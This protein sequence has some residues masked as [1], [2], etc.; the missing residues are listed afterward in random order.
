MGLLDFEVV[1]AS[2]DGLQHG[3]LCDWIITDITFPP[4]YLKEL[5]ELNNERKKDAEALGDTYKPLKPT[6]KDG[7]MAIKVAAVRRKIVENPDGTTTS[8]VV[9]KDDGDGL[10]APDYVATATF[11]HLPPQK[12]L[13]IEG[14]NGRYGDM[15]SWGGGKDL[16]DGKPSRT[17]L[18]ESVKPIKEKTKDGSY[19]SV[20]DLTP[21]QAEQ[22]ATL[23]NKENNRKNSWK[24][25]ISMWEEASEEDRE[26]FLMN[27]IAKRLFICNITDGKPEYLKLTEGIVFRAFVERNGNSIYPNITATIYDASSNKSLMHNFYACKYPSETMLTFVKEVGKAIQRKIVESREKEKAALAKSEE[28]YRN[29]GF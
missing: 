6:Y 24:K 7:G 27:I 16:K 26:T 12:H 4:A 15:F 8:Q 14:K 23:I 2:V 19:I 28:E 9:W 18:F 21:G 20:S 5:A 10:L 17:M 22:Y 3:E 13:T 1:R 11:Q 25:L 29:V